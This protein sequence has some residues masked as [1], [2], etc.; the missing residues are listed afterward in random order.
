MNVHPT[1]DVDLSQVTF[2][3]IS[4]TFPLG[5][6]L[7][8]G[9]RIVIVKNQAVFATIYDT[10]AIR[11]APGNYS[12]SL[13]ND[14]EEIVVINTLGVDV[15]R[16][17]Y[18]DVPPWPAEA[19]GDGYTLTLIAPEGSPDH[20]VPQ[21]WR[22]SVLPGGSPSASDAT[23]FQGDPLADLDGDGLTALAEYAFG[24]IDGD[25]N[26]SLEAELEISSEDFDDGHGGMAEYLTFSYRRN[27]AADDIEFAVVVSEDL[28]DWQ[29]D[30]TEFV[31]SSA[32]GDGTEKVTVRTL[33]PVSDYEK[34]FIRVNV[35][36]WP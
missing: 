29:N 5:V 11:I 24:T 18:N 7:P 4:Y 13:S 6:S 15:Q 17:T 22:I 26:S 9:E 10:A 1:N 3:G 21:N 34:R 14:G 16:F 27:L 35:S 19:D 28:V 31:R 36:T 30:Q 12:S 20:N 32:N 25:A 8:V 2:D 23:M 33:A